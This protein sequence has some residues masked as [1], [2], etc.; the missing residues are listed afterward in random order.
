MD[1]RTTVSPPHPSR[2]APALAG[3]LHDVRSRLT[4]LGSFAHLLEEQLEVNGATSSARSL[5]EAVRANQEQLVLLVE[6]LALLERGASGQTC[7][8]GEALSDA[9]G[10][11]QK[12]LARSQVSL[13]LPGFFPDR[14]YERRCLGAVVTQVL[15]AC[16]RAMARV[17]AGSVTVAAV[18]DEDATTLE[19]LLD[20]RSGSEDT[21]AQGLESA[22]RGCEDFGSAVLSAALAQLGGR[23]DVERVDLRPRVVLRLPARGGSR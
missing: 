6:G 9:S 23:V 21:V 14:Q 11:L 1:H 10:H 18:A 13:K 8:V 2:S 5:L 22:L 16:S 17:E 12:F 7:A 15:M 4:A 3:F 19:F 20:W